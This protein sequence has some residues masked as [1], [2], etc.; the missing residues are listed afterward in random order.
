MIVEH[1]HGYRAIISY[2]L[3]SLEIVDDEFPCVRRRLGFGFDL[4]WHQ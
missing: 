1:G 3:L 2:S 4:E